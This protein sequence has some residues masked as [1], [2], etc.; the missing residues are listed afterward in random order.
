MAHVGFRVFR[1][2]A[3]GEGAVVAF[4]G[5]AQ[6]PKFALASPLFIHFP[7]RVTVRN[8]E[9][10]EGEASRRGDRIREDRLRATAAICDGITLDG[11]GQAGLVAERKQGAYLNSGGSSGPGFLKA[12]RACIRSS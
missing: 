12:G 6:I 7:V 2:T 8:R 1:G 9:N 4:V 10:L 5:L 3:P 11:F